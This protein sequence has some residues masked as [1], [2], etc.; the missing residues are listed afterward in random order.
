[1]IK[2]RLL[3]IETLV[4]DEGMVNALKPHIEVL[5]SDADEWSA[6]FTRCKLKKGTP[7][8]TLETLFPGLVEAVLIETRKLN[9]EGLRAEEMIIWDGRKVRVKPHHGYLD[10]RNPDEFTEFL[11]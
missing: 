9:R 7:S 3:G 5:E 11:V 8:D 10:P 6:A 2:L 1:V 4:R